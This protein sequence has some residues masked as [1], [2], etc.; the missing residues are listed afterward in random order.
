MNYVWLETHTFL[1][2]VI[3]V[4]KV[5]L[6]NGNK[7]LCRKGWKTHRTIRKVQVKEKDTERIH[8]HRGVNR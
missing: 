1:N 8:V 4:E 7:L 6:K 5:Q 3:N 2:G